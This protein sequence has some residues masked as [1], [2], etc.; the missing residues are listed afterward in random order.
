[1]KSSFSRTA[2]PRYLRSLFSEAAKAVLPICLLLVV[3]K[4][5]FLGLTSQNLAGVVRGMSDT[6]LIA[7]GI[8]IIVFGLSFFLQG[9]DHSLLPLGR[10]V[11]SALPQTARL[12]SI[13]LFSL[14]LGALATVAE[15]D[16]KVYVDK[17]IVFLG[18]RVDKTVLMAAVAAGA[19]LGLTLGILRIALRIRFA[20][21]LL[22]L[23]FGAGVLTIFCPH[24]LNLASWDIA[25]VVSGS[26]TVPLFL[27]LGIGLAAVMGGQSPGTAGFGLITL[28]SLGPVIAVLILGLATAG[29]LPDR[30]LDPSPAAKVEAGPTGLPDRPAQESFLEPAKL[31]RTAGH[32]LRIIIP[33]YLFLFIFQGLVLRS[34]IHHLPAVFTGA[35]MLVFGLVLFFE[36]LEAGFFPLTEGVGRL[37]PRAVPAA[38]AN[39]GL[40]LV[41]GLAVTFAEPAVLVFA[42]QVEKATAGAIPKRFLYLILGV[43]V[44]FGFGL[45]VAVIWFNLPLP[46]VLLPVLL[47]ELIL[48]FFAAERYALLAWDALGVTSGAI[49]VPFF[50]A[51]GLGLASSAPRGSG[52]AGLGLIIMASVG[53]V[54]SLL[55]VGVV[56]GRKTP[57]GRH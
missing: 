36:G 51:M 47:V 8:L 31:A 14:I 17:T 1:M 57:Q 29:G 34:P 16:L 9:L 4:A 48:T 13:I 32:V 39:I 5:V 55:V 18:G 6:L 26:V 23:V 12:W 30:P 44:A 25:P 11:G 56:V 54:L 38:W 10:N 35:G 7:V 42:K 45:G 41:L 3:L 50:M 20:F 24:P 40:C 33:V 15:P 21:V 52:M 19:A 46:A 28:A 2:W 27:A 37:M 49:T 22:P 43:G 53:P